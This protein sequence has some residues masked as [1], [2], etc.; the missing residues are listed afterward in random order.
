MKKA[1]KFLLITGLILALP[2]IFKGQPPSPPH[3]NGGSG[4]DGDNTVVGGAAPV[5]GGLTFLLI[6]GAAYGS[7]RV[8]R[9]KKES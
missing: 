2:I 4:P 6:L 5:D 3:P 7:R 1:I 9:M 8:Y